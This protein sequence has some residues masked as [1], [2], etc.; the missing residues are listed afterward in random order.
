MAKYGIGD[1]V[2]VRARG[3]DFYGVIVAKGTFGKYWR[4]SVESFDYLYYLFGL[5]ERDMK[6]IGD[7]MPEVYNKRDY[8]VPEDAIYVGRPSKWGN[9]FK[10]GRDGTRE[11][12]IRAFEAYARKYLAQE[13]DWLDV[14]K[15]KDL[16]C[17]C[18]P[19]DCHADVLIRLV[20]DTGRPFAIRSNR[21]SENGFRILLC[22]GQ[23]HEDGTISL[24]E[25]FNDVVN[26][27][28][29]ER[30]R[31]DLSEHY[32]TMDAL[33]TALESQDVRCIYWGDTKEYQYI[34]KR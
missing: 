29:G 2:R 20:N 23:L 1:H 7:K 18:A 5:R 31:V 12:V 13:P 8:N 30:D 4:Y 22:K 3:L 25:T 19:E 10:V 33:L 21:L 32:E 26:S 28:T 11:E 27:K 14:L 16:V 24:T 9:P 34:N 15:G 17:W 6:F